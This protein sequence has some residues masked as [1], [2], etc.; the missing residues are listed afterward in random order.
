MVPVDT[1]DTFGIEVG[2][3]YNRRRYF[4]KQVEYCI[5]IA[6][7]SIRAKNIVATEQTHDGI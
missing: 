1:C 7:D 4:S 5:R 2:D 3:T 6:N